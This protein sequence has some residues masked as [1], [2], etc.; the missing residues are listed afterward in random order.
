MSELQ[1]VRIDELETIDVPAWDSDAYSARTA[2]SNLFDMI[3]RTFLG[4]LS[5]DDRLPAWQVAALHCWAN[6]DRR[7]HCPMPAGELTS[8]LGKKS[9]RDTRKVVAEA[10]RRGWLAPGSNDRCLI[11][12]YEVT[13]KAGKRRLRSV[14]E[15]H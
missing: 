11:A 1:D 4:R 3:G 9:D 12:P 7:G 15:F 2:D 8:M 13:Y 6:I 5:A 14:C 10:V